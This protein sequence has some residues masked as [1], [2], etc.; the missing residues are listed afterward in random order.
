MTDR[1]WTGFAAQRAGCRARR[2]IAATVVAAALVSGPGAIAGETWP[3]SVNAHY[4]LKFQGIEVGTLDMVTTTSGGGYAMSGGAKL[5]VLFGAFKVNAGGSADGRLEADQPQPR[6][7]TFD[8]KGGSKQGATRLGFERGVAT[9][10][11][12]DPPPVPGEG[13]VPLLDQHKAG[14]LDPLSAILQLTRGDGR[15]CE[16]QAAVFDGKHRFDIVLAFKRQA[17][18]ET[19]ASRGRGEPVFVCSISYHPIAGH[20]Y[21]AETAAFATNRD[22]EVVMRRVPG[23]EITIPQAVIIPTGWGTASMDLDHVEITSVSRGRIAL[24][25]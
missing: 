14:V 20:K 10:V 13:R 8:W 12:V 4:K 18:V 11:A 3:A 19:K 6:S 2:W 15:P 21:K 1:R 24:T 5:S 22:M 23:L 7:F 9:R 17:T 25:P 16:R